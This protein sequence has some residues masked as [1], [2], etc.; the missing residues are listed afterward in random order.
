MLKKRCVQRQHSA[1]LSNTH[2]PRWRD[3]STPTD[4]CTRQ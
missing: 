4:P 3:T 2:P 1:V